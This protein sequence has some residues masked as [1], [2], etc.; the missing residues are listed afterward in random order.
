MFASPSAVKFALEA[1]AD[2][3]RVHCYSIGPATSDA[4]RAAGLTA[5]GQA[6]T[7]DNAGLTQ[8]IMA[9]ESR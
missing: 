8:A 4:L 5:S 3:A 9:R 7:P 2:L 6:A 1:A